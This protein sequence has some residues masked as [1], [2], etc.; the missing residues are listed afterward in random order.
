MDIFLNRLVIEFFA[1]GLVHLDKQVTYKYSQLVLDK[2]GRVIHEARQSL[3]QMV[4]EQLD[5]KKC[6]KKI[7]IDTDHTPNTNINSKWIIFINLKCKDIKLLED[8]IGENPND[9]EYGDAQRPKP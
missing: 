8:S 5:T 6:R 1:H 9:L 3:Q 2:R 7:N 4:P